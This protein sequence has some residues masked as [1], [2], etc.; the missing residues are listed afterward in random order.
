MTGSNGKY[1]YL[2]AEAG[3]TVP[4]VHYH[5]IPRERTGESVG[6]SDMTDAERK[7]LVLGEGPRLLLERE[8]GEEISR[9]IRGGIKRELDVLLDKNELSLG[10]LEAEGEEVDGKLWL[11][12]PGQRV[13]L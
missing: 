9:L 7:N 11:G 13:R 4:H 8:D 2:G 6:E 5:I 3:Q 10:N 12:S 1:A